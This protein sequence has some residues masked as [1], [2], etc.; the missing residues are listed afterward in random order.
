MDGSRTQSA[1]TS[2]EA[3]NILIEAYRRMPPWEKAARVSAL[4]RSC[5][6]LAR[7]GI[8][9]RHPEAGEPEIRLRLA[10][11]WLDRETMIAVFGWD[12]REKGYG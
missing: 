8:R 4:T 3:E 1:D 6:E 9:L 5:L 12:P 10:S 2:R 11:L 7:A